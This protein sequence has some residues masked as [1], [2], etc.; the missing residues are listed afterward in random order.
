[1]PNKKPKFIAICTGEYSYR[2]KGTFAE[3]E[4]S[5]CIYGLDKEGQVWKFLPPKKDWVKLEDIEVNYDKQLGKETEKPATEY[6][7]LKGFYKDYSKN[8]DKID[9]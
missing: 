5:H 7:G 9:Y 2:T 1:M 3:T 8:P 4:H 6:K